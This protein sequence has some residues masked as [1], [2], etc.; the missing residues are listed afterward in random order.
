MA[1]YVW[2]DS[3]GHLYRA[4]DELS[5]T[6]LENV[7]RLLT[8]RIAEFENECKRLSNL[9]LDESYTREE[10]ARAYLILEQAQRNLAAR[11]GEQWET[12]PFEPDL[13]P[14]T[15]SPLTKSG[16]IKRRISL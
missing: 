1:E 14:R 3:G 9:K 4:F 15:T 10:Q 11:A 2:K 7:I 6:H 8:R 5:L 12:E 16:E 13:D